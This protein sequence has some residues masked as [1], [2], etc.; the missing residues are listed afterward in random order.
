LTNGVAA[1]L[2]LRHDGQ[3]YSKRACRQRSPKKARGMSRQSNFA[4]HES[5]H[6]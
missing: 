2:R 4:I 3:Q 6:S 5:I 1:A